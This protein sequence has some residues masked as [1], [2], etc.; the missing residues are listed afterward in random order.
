[1]KDRNWFLA[2]A[3]SGLLTLLVLALPQQVSAQAPA[4]SF[5]RCSGCSTTGGWCTGLVPCR[6]GDCICPLPAHDY[7]LTYNQCTNG[8]LP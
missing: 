4:C 1:M 5:W 7:H 8:Q 3:V 2:A 6:V